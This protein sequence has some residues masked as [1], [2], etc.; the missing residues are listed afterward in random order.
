MPHNKK[1]R[2]KSSATA[3]KSTRSVSA[4]RKSTTNAYM[5]PESAAKKIFMRLPSGE[6]ALLTM[7]TE[8]K[9]PGRI[10]IRGLGGSQGTLAAKKIVTMLRSGEVTLLTMSTEFKR[11]GRIVIRGLGGS[12]STIEASAYAPNSRARALLQGVK[13][14][15]A[16]LKE[17]GGAFDLEQVQ[18]VLNNVSRQ[19]VEKRVKDGSLLAVPGPNNRRRYPT[20]QFTREGVVPGLKDVQE[21]LPTRNPWAVLNF[22]VRPDDRLGGR[23]PIE[24]LRNGDV[25]LVVSAARGMGEQ[26]G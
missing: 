9:R 25:D 23:K 14:A 3:A 12:Q 19:A 2:S 20:I 5:L 17:A 11:P 1:T 4:K 10:M 18:T 24:V 15:E 8:I 21:A 16:D 22:L 26:G 13:I 7:S 6:V